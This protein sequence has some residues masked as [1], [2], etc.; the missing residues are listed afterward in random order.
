MECDTLGPSISAL[1]DGEE[2]SPEAAQHIAGC[3]NC[4]EALRE[5]AQIGV[6]L[7]LL[8]ANQLKMPALPQVARRTRLFASVL[9]QN[10]RVPRFVAAICA[11][12]IIALAG[13]WARTRAQNSARYFQYRFMFDSERGS[14]SV[15]GVAQVCAMGCAHLT[16]LSGTQHLAAVLNVQKVNGGRVYLTLRV[17]RF[18]AGPD[19][20]QLEDE[21]SDVPAIPYVYEPGKVLP[22]P[23]EGGSQVNLEGVIADSPEGVPGWHD[24]PARPAENQ[25]VVR[26]GILIRDGQV[27]AEFPGSVSA[28]GS[29]GNSQAGFY[30]YIPTQGLF[31]FSLGPLEKSTEG[32]ADYGQIRFT[33]SGARY[34]L[35]SGSQITGGSQPRHIWILHLPSYRLSQGFPNANNDSPRIGSSPNIKVVLEQM[36]ALP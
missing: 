22:I 33:E 28:A 34:M 17:K 11:L 27:V 6:E 13:G 4:R 1:Y 25:I 20:K 5:Y 7:R 36:H 8:E 19:V 15:G 12:A 9:T 2:V 32:R 3:V 35:L 23:V 31:A 24:M 18:E 29:I 26:Q 16:V 14:G 10:M 30:A 21:M